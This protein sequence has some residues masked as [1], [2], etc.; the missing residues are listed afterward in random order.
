MACVP[1]EV[2]E[3]F[4]RF[5]VDGTG[6][7]SRDE[8]AEVLKSLDAAW[9]DDSIDQLLAMADQSGDGELQ[10][11]EF[12]HWI[13]AEDASVRSGQELGDFTLVIS[14]SS[15]K[16]LNGSYVQQ[17]GVAF[18]RRPVFFCAANSMYL[19]YYKKRGRHRWQ[20]FP[21]LGLKSCCLLRTKRSAHLPGEGV[22]WH[23]W[24]KVDEKWAFT[25][26]PEMTC[27]L[28]LQE[29][30]PEE[31]CLKA[32]ELIESHGHEGKDGKKFAGLGLYEKS[33]DIFNGRPVY[34]KEHM[35]LFYQ[36]SEK[37]NGTAVDDE[38]KMKRWKTSP[39]LKENSMGFSYS[40][41]TESYNPAAA[42]W[43]C[44]GRAR[45]WT[46]ITPAAMEAVPEGWKD[47]NFPP[48]DSSI[49]DLEGA[50][51]G[52]YSKKDVEWVRA[53]ELSKQRTEDREP[54]LLGDPEPQDARQG[55]LGNCW[56]IS[57]ISGLAEFPGY[58]E[59]QVFVTKEISV[60]GKYEFNFYD[61]ATREWKVVEIDDYLPCK[62]RAENSNIN[63]LLF[64]E[65][66]DGKMWV[67][68]LE[69]AFAKL[70]GSYVQ[71]WGGAEYSAWRC[72]TGCEDV[73]QY[74]APHG[75]ELPEWQVTRTVAVLSGPG[76][77]QL[78]ELSEGATVQEV[79]RHRQFVRFTKVSGD[80]PEEG[81][82][83]YYVSGKRVAKRSSVFPWHMYPI[84]GSG[85]AEAV[86]EETMWKMA[87]ELD[88][89][90][91]MLG[92]GVHYSRKDSKREGLVQSHAYTLLHVKEVAGY[93]MVATRNPWG[94]GEWK[95]PWHDEGEE[96]EANPEVTKALDAHLERDGVFWMDWEDFTW[97]MSLG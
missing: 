82:M 50:S 87:M 27:S 97:N 80:G 35:Y 8:L 57:S 89:S 90:N 9:E 21:K 53:V 95:G 12:M 76:G 67:P 86:D 54:L 15:R 48:E 13:F 88:E 84:D 22:A 55:G 25:P 6:S 17:K 75:F 14:G 45:K 92:T 73:W 42:T 68:L 19:F 78:G 70:W 58:L 3:A 26:E 81:W 10:I 63:E 94:D 43:M 83:P 52:R 16:K 18:Q 32:P 74:G 40:E 62:R 44:G 7:I 28:K 47:P 1:V 5:D 66:K 59:E 49:G 24:K 38:S 39:Q 72:L 91:Y 96:W 61:S 65:M 71:L 31:L 20:I 30:S 29:E 79:E 41:A 56:L 36:E 85:H 93:R 33:E 64:A 37:R 23:V 60:H 46:I 69:K 11:K 34:K 51:H 4:K 2:V 77:E